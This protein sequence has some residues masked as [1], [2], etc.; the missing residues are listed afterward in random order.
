MTEKTESQKCD[1]VMDILYRLWAMLSATVYLMGG[2]A[3]PIEDE[4]AYFEVWIA[5]MRDRLKKAIAI[6]GG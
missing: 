3:H 6:M 4:Y 5:D 2:D 1:E